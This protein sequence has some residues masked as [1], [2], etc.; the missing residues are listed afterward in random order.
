MA[1]QRKN[2]ISTLDHAQMLIR[3]CTENSLFRQKLISLLCLP[4][5]NRKMIIS[6]WIDSLKKE[7]ESKD[8]LIKALAFLDDEDRAQ[9]VLEELKKIDA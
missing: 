8:E 9:A 7:A 5:E 4:Y 2:F 1:I 3:V 6:A